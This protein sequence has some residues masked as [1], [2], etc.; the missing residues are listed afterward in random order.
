MKFT[1]NLIIRRVSSADSGAFTGLA[2][3]WNRDRHND[4]IAPGAFAA[5]VA[6]LKAGTR[7]I[8]LLQNHDTSAQIGVISAA[9]ET[10]EG[11][12]VRGKLVLGTPAA[13]R[14]HALM[15]AAAM[16]LSVGFI[17]SADPEDDG[18]GGN[19][20]RSVD[21]VEVS[22]VATPS[23]RESRV[24]TVKSLAEQPMAELERL[25]RDGELPDMPR[26]LAKKLARAFRSALDGDDDEYDS[27]E[28]AAALAALQT[29]K[30]NL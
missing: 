2:S 30:G 29:L 23:N 19:I 20:Y 21:L 4:R 3:T 14:A 27:D 12:E 28:I 13:D 18:D 24:L 10:S 1:E 16:G 25:L 26:R 11:L 22:A 17:P 6:A 5:S 7:R 15:R 8:P 9:D